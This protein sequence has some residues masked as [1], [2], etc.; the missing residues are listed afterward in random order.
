MPDMVEPMVLRS[1]HLPQSMEDELRGVAFTLR[2]SK[3]DLLRY[4]ISREL[5]QFK[6]QHG[7]W[8]RWSS[9][10]I[11]LLSDKVQR[12]ESVQRLLQRDIERIG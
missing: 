10:T 1:F 9:D 4:F 11:R 7:D 6:Q 12:D 3:A 8:R 2:C 5:S